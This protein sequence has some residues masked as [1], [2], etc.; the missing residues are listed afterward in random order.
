MCLTPSSF[1]GGCVSFFMVSFWYTFCFAHTLS[2]EGFS[3]SSPFDRFLFC[4]SPGFCLPCGSF[5]ALL[6]Q[7]SLLSSQVGY[8]GY[9][10][11]FVSLV[12]FYRLSAFAVC[13]LR[14]WSYC[15]YFFLFSTCAFSL[16]I[17]SSFGRRFPIF[18]LF[19]GCFVLTC[20]SP[21][22]VRCLWLVHC[23]LLICIPPL[24]F[25][26]LSRVF[27]WFS[28]LPSSLIL[29][30]SAPH[31]VPLL[32]VLC[33]HYLL[34]PSFSVW[35]FR[36]SWLFQSVSLSQCF[37]FDLSSA[38]CCGC[39]SAVFISFFNYYDFYRSQPTR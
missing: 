34:L 37:N 11:G 32:G 38:V 36:F 20:G 28:F 24:R 8:S 3:V 5:L 4:G 6:P 19:P 22:F 12:F 2:S 1:S 16:G 29:S 18:R 25:I 14:I 39:S 9:R 21:F 10:S 15:L 7:L 23:G 35:T 31:W 17:P 13:L 33:F 30:T 26:C 27:L